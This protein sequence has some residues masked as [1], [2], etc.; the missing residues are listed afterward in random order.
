[1]LSKAIRWCALFLAVVSPVVFVGSLIM[2]EW[3]TAAMF[4][5]FSF[6]GVRELRNERKRCARLAEWPRDRVASAVGEVDDP[7]EAARRLREIDDRLRLLDSLEL[8]T[9]A[10]S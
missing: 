1:M 7:I 4:A 6:Y 10:R 5:F 8:V 3:W 2:G 9:R